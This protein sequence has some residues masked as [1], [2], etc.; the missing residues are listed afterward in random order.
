MNPVKSQS[1]LQILTPLLQGFN[2]GL[3]ISLIYPENTQVLSPVI[4]VKLKKDLIKQKDLKTL[5]KVLGNII[6]EKKLGNL[7]YYFIHA[8]D[9]QN[10]FINHFQNIIGFSFTE[11]N[12]PNIQSLMEAIYKNRNKSSSQITLFNLN[13]EEKNLRQI[14]PNKNP[15]IS[16][17]LLRQIKILKEFEV[18]IN[19]KKPRIFLLNIA[20]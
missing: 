14:N 1:Q 6:Q 2:D 7:Q 5:L 20:F 17:S 15:I 11:M 8:D 19:P 12:V 4:L 10:I 18:S 9:G 16:P 3:A 13:L